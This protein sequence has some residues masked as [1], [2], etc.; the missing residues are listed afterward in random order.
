MVHS[1]GNDSDHEKLAPHAFT[2]RNAC[3]AQK[4]GQKDARIGLV[5]F[6][7]SIEDG[8]LLVGQSSQLLRA[9]VQRLALVGLDGQLSRGS[10]RRGVFHLLGNKRRLPGEERGSKRR[11]GKSRRS[12]HHSAILEQSSL[13]QDEGSEFTCNHPYR[14][15]VSYVV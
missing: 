5:G 4:I 1:F 8:D 7:M 13:S 3:F 15:D 2:Q 9:K 10:G 14:M 6:A 12:A 11:N